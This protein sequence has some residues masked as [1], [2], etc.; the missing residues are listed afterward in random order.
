MVNFSAVVCLLAFSLNE[1]KM[2]ICLT[3]FQ[4]MHINVAG[5]EFDRSSISG[6][7]ALLIASLKDKLSPLTS[8]VGTEVTTHLSGGRH[9]DG[10]SADLNIDERN[11]NS[12]RD[13]DR[14]QGRYEE[15]RSQVT[16]LR[17]SS[18]SQLVL[19]LLARQLV[20]KLDPLELKEFLGLLMESLP[21]DEDVAV[22][23]NHQQLNAMG[24]E[25]SSSSSPSLTSL[26]GLA[27]AKYRLSDGTI[28]SIRDGLQA[29]VIDRYIYSFIHSSFRKVSCRYHLL[30]HL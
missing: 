14:D 6:D 18:V 25:S 26:I 23:M 27:A 1:K 19:E 30:L 2:K 4:R 10:S 5:S 8:F 17:S 9:K 15:Y 7:T 29:A 13:R 24:L 12:E 11:T 20:D 22:A 21:I 28:I 3:D 16:A